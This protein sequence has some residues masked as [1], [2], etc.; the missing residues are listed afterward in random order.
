MKQV[1]L[2]LSALVF[3]SGCAISSNTITGKI[4]IKGEYPHTFI[5]MKVRN[6]VYYNVVGD[7]KRVL[8]ASYQGKRITLA[9]HFVSSAQ[10]PG[11]PA[12]FHA[13]KVVEILER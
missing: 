13:T 5:A 1:I 9:G 11:M 12:R 6:R 4:V 3:F 10:G 7:L 8:K 2:L